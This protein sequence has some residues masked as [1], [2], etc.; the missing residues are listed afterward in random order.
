ME[1]LNY[2][3]KNKKYLSEVSQIAISKIANEHWSAVCEAVDFVNS[4]GS[5]PGIDCQI[6]TTFEKFEDFEN[7]RSSAWN[8]KGSKKQTEVE[9]VNVVIYKGF[10]LQKNQK[11]KDSAILD[12]GDFRVVLSAEA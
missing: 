12:L 6:A 5:E 9:G 3:E 7:A 10:Q 1:N 4:G 8:E 11:R 2:I